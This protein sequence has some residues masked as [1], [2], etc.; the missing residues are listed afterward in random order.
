MRI[1][2][3]IDIDDD[4]LN[5]HFKKDHIYP[6]LGKYMYG[7]EYGSPNKII[8]CGG[9]GV[10]IYA[11]EGEYEIISKQIVKNEEDLCS[12]KVE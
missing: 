11:E 6:V 7:G 3:L 5:V 4:Y 12:R 10:Y 9:H 8:Y 1:K 2:L